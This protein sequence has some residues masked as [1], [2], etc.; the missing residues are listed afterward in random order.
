MPLYDSIG[1]KYD[2]TRCADPFIVQRLADHLNLKSGG[3]YL[4]AACGSG[5]YTIALA[6]KGA[7]MTGIDESSLMIVSAQRKNSKINWIIGGAE[8]M[9][10]TDNEF[11]GV[12]CTLALH[13]FK[14]AGV[15]FREVYR[16]IDKGQFVI[17]TSTP[18]QMK[19]YWLNEYFPGIMS[20]SINQMPSLK[21]IEKDLKNAGFNSINSEPY[22]VKDD[23]K[24]MFLYS[25]KNRPEIYLIPEMRMGSSSF[26][27]L[28]HYDEVAEGCRMLSADI[29]SGRIKEVMESFKNNKGDY[30]FVIAEK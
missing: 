9:S 14:S 25:G 8:D 2:A 19:G 27:N 3:K 16:V 23:L 1:K 10:F 15:I 29:E 24:D 7:V 4:D 11:R 22:L 21:S 30:L 6:Q 13:H 17:F 5:N 18:E 20:A 28:A 26:S 12:I